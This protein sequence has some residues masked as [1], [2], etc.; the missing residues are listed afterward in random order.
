M[1]EFYIAH[2]LHWGARWGSWTRH[3]ATSW[4]VAGSIPSGV[5]GIFNWHNPSGWTM[6]HGS[7]QPLTQ[8]IA[9]NIC[10]GVKAARAL[11]WQPRHLHV[12]IVLKFGRLILLEPSGLVQARWR[13]GCCFYIACNFDNKFTTP[14]QQNAH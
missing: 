10:W 12:S 5:T 6:Y 11:R 13:D 4:K 2:S 14:N 8:M 7:T 9:M 1:G 3:C